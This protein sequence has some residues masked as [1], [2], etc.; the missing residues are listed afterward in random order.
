MSKVCVLLG[1]RSDIAKALIPFLE[2][3]GWTVHGWNR[4]SGPLPNVRWDLFLCAL[5]QVAPV[6]HWWTL[7]REDIADCMNSNLLLPLEL[8]RTLWEKRNPDA[9]V[10]MLGGSNPQKIMDGYLPYN[11]SKMALLKAVEQIDH[12]SPDAKVFC[13]GPGYVRT[14][15]HKPTLAANWPNE[16]IARGDDGMPIERIY[17][18][19]KWCLE[20]PKEAVGGRNVCAS[21]PWD[22]VVMGKGKWGVSL[23]ED[24]A[25]NPDM[26]KLRRIE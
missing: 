21:D 15:I 19:L 22:G 6:G 18:C 24:L 25:A 9:S 17:G 16:R 20:A 3:D 7:H 13:I 26:Y 4:D 5:G 1:N 12:E 23:A 11:V 14:K 8:L 2:A 10:C